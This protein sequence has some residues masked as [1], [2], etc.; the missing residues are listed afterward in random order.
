MPPKLPGDAYVVSGILPKPGWLGRGF[1]LVV[2]IVFLLSAFSVG[3]NFHQWV[4]SEPYLDN[5]GLWALALVL[6]LSMS[7]VINLGLSVRWGQK[8]QLVV[9]VLAVAAIAID[10]LFYRRLWALPL[11]LLFCVWCLLI[12]IP[13]GIALVLAAIM[14]TPGCEMRTYAA[15]LARLRGQSAAEHYCPGGIDFIDRW[16]ARWRKETK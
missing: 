13:L 2:G 14:G 1:R 8:A 3:R 12:A 7:E 5:F 15:L 11:G 4:F 10:Y 6:F 9:L 16:Q